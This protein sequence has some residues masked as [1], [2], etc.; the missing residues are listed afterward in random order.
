VAAAYSAVI[1]AVVVKDTSLFRA[2]R[3]V[4]EL[5]ERVT[6]LESQRK[7]Q[8]Q[9]VMMLTAGTNQ[10]DFL[11]PLKFDERW[12]D[13]RSQEAVGRLVNYAEFAISKSDYDHAELFY[14]E[15]SQFQ[16]TVTIP[17]YEGRLAYRK[18]DLSGAEEKWLEAVKQDPNGEYPDLRLYLG[19]LY[20]QMGRVGEAK[21]YLKYFGEHSKP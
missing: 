14:N 2:P 12:R 16:P 7:Q 4:Q 21:Q 1:G 20:Y 10:A 8:D 3:E 18:G 6:E 5:R 17:Y 11:K 19:I 15:A 9:L 13:E